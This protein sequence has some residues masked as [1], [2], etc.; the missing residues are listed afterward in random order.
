MNQDASRHANNDSRST[1][2]AAGWFAG[3]G[4][5][6]EYRFDLQ[7]KAMLQQHRPGLR[8]CLARTRE[9]KR[10]GELA[11]DRA[12]KEVYHALASRWGLLSQDREFLAQ[13]DRLLGCEREASGDPAAGYRRNLAGT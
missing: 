13:M 1:I 4:V 11:T 2:G 3:G 7:R 6:A 9:C 10:L 5:G 12:S 8:L